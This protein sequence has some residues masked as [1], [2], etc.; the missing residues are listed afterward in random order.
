MS[1]R[2]STGNRGGRTT[3][4]LADSYDWFVRNRAETGKTGRSQH[5]T[6]AKQGALRVLKAGT[7]LLPR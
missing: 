2:P 1:A 7:R 6:I 3:E 5:R 4:M